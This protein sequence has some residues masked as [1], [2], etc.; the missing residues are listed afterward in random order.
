MVSKIL[1]T[2][3]LAGCLLPMLSAC[4]G[5]VDVRGDEFLIGEKLEVM[6]GVNTDDGGETRQI[7]IFDE[8]VR[9]IH[10]FDVAEMKHLR[11]LSVRSP[12][13]THYVAAH[14]RG[15]Y[16]IDFTMKGLTVFDRD[17]RAQ[18]DPLAM[19]GQA[20]SAALK[21]EAGL[22]VVYDTL[23][24][25]GLVQ[26]GA[27][28]Q[29]ERANIFGPRISGASIAAGDLTDD[30]RLVLAMSDGSLAIADVDQSLRT[31]SWVVTR[32]DVAMNDVNWVAPLKGTSQVLLRAPGRLALFDIDARVKLAEYPLSSGQAAEKLSR[33][34]DP[35][36]VLRDGDNLT[37]VY[38]KNGAFET[39]TFFRQS[40]HLLLSLL[41]ADRDQWSY[42]DA[43][44]VRN[45]FLTNDID[46]VRQTRVLKRRRLSDLATLIN[47][48]LPKDTQLRL[49]DSYVFALYPNKL[50]YAVRYNVQNEGTAVLKLFNMGSL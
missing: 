34:H 43:S 40:R 29:V 14:P 26:L 45:P 19:V 35:H 15:N 17:G 9:K 42:I 2:A 5:A 24:N 18:T 39:R 6:S 21:A 33:S 4:T 30:G 16:V 7:T 27:T 25:V 20:K 37:L 49:A 23:M 44:S 47:K 36:V 3:V 28:G 13:E 1:K 22:L 38:P 46:A 11:T 31:G 50:G 12:G 8:T 32:Y 41:D 48:D 10:L